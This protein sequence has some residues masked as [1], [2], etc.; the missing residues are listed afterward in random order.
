MGLEPPWSVSSL[1][2]I[3]RMVRDSVTLNDQMDHEERKS[4]HVQRIRVER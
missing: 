1:L 3:R 2:D 4:P